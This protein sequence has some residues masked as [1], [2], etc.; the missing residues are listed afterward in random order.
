M[1]SSLDAAREQLIEAAC[2]ADDDVM[3][4]YLEGEELR[5]EEL[6]GAVKK[7]IASGALYPVFVGSSTKNIGVSKFLDAVVAYCPA[8]P[9]VAPRTST[10]GCPCT[11]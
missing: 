10:S 6:T 1:S 8:P 5:A 4:K 2:E 9:D 3:A 7:G 11:H